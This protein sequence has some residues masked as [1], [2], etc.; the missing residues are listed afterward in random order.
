M[1]HMQGA[2]PGAILFASDV[3]DLLQQFAELYE[4]LQPADVFCGDLFV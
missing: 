2:I 4:V 3:V 1:I